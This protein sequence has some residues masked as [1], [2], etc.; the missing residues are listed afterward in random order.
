MRR[1]ECALVTG[2][3]VT[4]GVVLDTVALPSVRVRA[5]SLLSHPLTVKRIWSSRLAPHCAPCLAP[6]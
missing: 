5:Q 4:A 6:G 2:V 3:H 1:R